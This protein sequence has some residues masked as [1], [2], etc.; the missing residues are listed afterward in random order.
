[1]T[2]SIIVLALGCACCANESVDRGEICAD[3]HLFLAEGRDGL[4]IGL[5]GGRAVHA[6]VLTL[7][8]G[9][10]AADAAIATALT[11][12]VEAA[13]SY[14]SFA[15]ILSMTYFDAATAKVQFLNAC[16]NTPLEE[17]DPLSIRTVHERTI[18]ATPRGRTALVPGFMAGVEAAHK[19]FGKIPLAEVFRHA[20]ALAD[21]GFAV[22]PQLA[23]YIRYRKD[24][25]ARLPETRAVFTRENGDFYREGD[26]F[27]QPELA[28]TLRQVA[29]HGAAYMY[30]GE[31]G[32]RFVDAVKRDGGCITAR[33]LEAYRVIWDHPLE[34][35]YRDCHVFAPGLSSMG[36]VD[37]VE[38][39]NLLELSDL[40]RSGVP[41]RSSA[42]LI[43]LMQITCNQVLSFAPSLAAERFPNKD[44]SPTARATKEHARWVWA[45]MQERAWPFAVFP[46]GAE[47]HPAHSSGV[48]VVDRWGNVAALTHSINTTIWGDTGIFVGGISVPDSA[49]FQQESI[50]RT[51]PGHRLPDPMCPLI[52]TRNG[53]PV[54]ASSAIGAGIH[55]K[56]VQVLA[57]VLEFGMDAQAAVDAPAFLLPDWS[58]T[59]PVAQ[60]GEGSFDKTV[61][62]GVTKLGQ[63]VKVLPR[64]QGNA[65]RGYWV[66]IE[67]DP[68]TGRLRAAGTAELPSHAEGY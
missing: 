38:A 11:Q 56:N 30:T 8:Q 47:G 2:T 28:V 44:F 57:N 53:K 29:E 32:R 55:Q 39:L 4:V 59:K 12:V 22:D 48:V 67:I 33:D 16:F 50:K 15:G 13:G 31:W 27:R 6:G 34:T 36:G 18:K 17:K 42:S 7:K 62:D 43:W 45:R 63:D 19:R 37:F 52:V 10:S 1:M 25:L 3:T 60:A 9:G 49:T 26:L 21:H 14:V 68:R 40:R 35:D 64:H 51:G 54:L 20:I 23:G 66:G 61:L 65:L 46:A 5:T 58:G 24:V 41:S